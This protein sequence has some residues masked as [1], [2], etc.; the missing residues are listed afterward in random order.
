MIGRGPEDNFLMR[1]ASEA[2]VNANGDVTAIV[3]DFR[4]GATVTW[5]PDGASRVGTSS[6]VDF[7][8]ARSTQW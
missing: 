6:R 8:P 7:G 1:G 2:T 3:S 5:T 4:G